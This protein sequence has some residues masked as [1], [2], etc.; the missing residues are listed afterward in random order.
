MHALAPI[1]PHPAS[2]HPA[3]RPLPS[4]STVSTAFTVGGYGPSKFA[5]ATSTATTTVDQ[6]LAKSDGT[7]NISGTYAG[8]V[9]VVV[10]DTARP[11]PTPIQ[12]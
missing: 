4:G 10:R 2:R 6:K 7:A 9:S 1:C 8:G 12:G 5:S 3:S 11:T